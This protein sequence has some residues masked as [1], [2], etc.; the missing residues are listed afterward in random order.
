MAKLTDEQVREIRERHLFQRELRM[1]S[2]PEDRL[3]DGA[4]DAKVAEEFGI[5]R[6]YATA[7]VE[8]SARPEA[9]GPIDVAREVKDRLHAEE[10]V[11]V[12]TEEANRRRRLRTRGID[13]EPREARVSTKVTIR[14]PLGDVVGEY[15]LGPGETAVTSTVVEGGQG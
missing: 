9:G 8:G 5:S 4:L 6:P 12:G 7:L 13:P 3:T 1:A 2:P 15:I 10:V 14:G 11:T